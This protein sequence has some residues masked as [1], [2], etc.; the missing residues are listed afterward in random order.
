M[1]NKELAPVGVIGTGS[2][3]TAVSL[4]LSKNS[5]VLCFSRDADVVRQINSG[6][7]RKKITLPSNIRATQSPEELVHACRI[8]FP[9]V[10][11]QAFRNA[12]RLFSPY[13]GPQHIL[14]HGT[15]GFDISA[16]I[17]LTK[18]KRLTRSD[19]HTMTEVIKQETVVIRIGCLSGPNL[20]KEI[21]DGQPTAT[22]LASPFDEV[23]RL[24]RKYL[25]SNQFFVF[26][27]H[28]IKG[29]EIA[30]SLKNIIAIGSGILGGLKMGK[31]IEAMLITRGLHEIMHFGEKMGAS[32]KSFLG[33]A[34]IGDLVA[35]ATS[36][37]SRN[38][39]FGY[40]IGTGM[41]MKDI[42]AESKEVIEGIRTLKMVYL[43]S[44][45][46]RINTPICNIIY[47]AVYDNMNIKR[48]IKHLMRLP[49]MDDVLF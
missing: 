39:T 14:I 28:D 37:L 24:G 21:L 9:V 11:S 30:G 2:F 7:S 25:S 48:A 17:S 3:G 10:S 40:K 38:Y 42:L 15:K 23:I 43:L 4:L 22:V 16:D 31:N 13:L 26:G 45:E 6:F 44:Q 27:S 35:T 36:T 19:V 32:N 41:S 49:H 47:R 34:G 12:I 46:Y 18:T 5:D 1:T 20:A 29:A 33:T 8:I